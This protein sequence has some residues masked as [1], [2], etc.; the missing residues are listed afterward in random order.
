MNHTRLFLGLFLGEYIF[1]KSFKKSHFFVNFLILLCQGLYKQLQ[2][3]YAIFKIL[4]VY[5]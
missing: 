1:L 2:K 3:T 4:E 5:L